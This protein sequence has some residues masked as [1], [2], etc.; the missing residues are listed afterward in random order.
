MYMAFQAKGQPEE[1]DRSGKRHVNPKWLS[2][3][4]GECVVRDC[5]R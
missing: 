4:G 1:R 3:S 2:V 5:E